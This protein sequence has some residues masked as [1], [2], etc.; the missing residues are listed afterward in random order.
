[1]KIVFSKSAQKDV[2]RLPKPIVEKLRLWVFSVETIG[3]VA[4]RLKGGKGLHDEPL[5]GKRIGQ[6]SVRLSRGYRAI[7]EIRQNG[8]EFISVEEVNKHDY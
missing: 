2:Q 4:T 7:Y 1:M 3:L 6:R 5:K 8:I